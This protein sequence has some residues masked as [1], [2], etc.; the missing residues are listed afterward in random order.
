[1]KIQFAWLYLDLVGFGASLLLAVHCAS[2]LFIFS[3]ASSASGNP[4]SVVTIAFI[5]IVT[6]HLW[7]VEWKK[8]TATIWGAVLLGIAQLI[9]RSQVK[10]PHLA[11]P[12]YLHHNKY[13]K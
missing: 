12:N 7:Q 10:Q 5:L 13:P 1:M 6:D 8:I 2:L 11:L 4:I 9:N 3:L